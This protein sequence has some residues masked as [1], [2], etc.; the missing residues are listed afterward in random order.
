MK[1][2]EGVGDLTFYDYN[3]ISRNYVFI[4]DNQPPYSIASLSAPCSHYLQ[5][6][7]Q[8]CSLTNIIV[9]LYHRVYLDPIRAR[10]NFLA[11]LKNKDM[12]FMDT[13]PAIIKIFLASSRS[14]KEYI[15]LE[16]MPIDTKECILT[17]AMP[18]FVWVCEI[19]LLDDF[20]NQLLT[21]VLLQDA[22]EVADFSD[23]TNLSEIPV[24]F[25]V[26]KTKVFTYSS[27][28]FKFFTTFAKSFNIYKANLH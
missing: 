22:T 17:T 26:Y 24:F 28:R 5:K 25:G 23:Q 12:E 13:D 18:K 11:V 8:N 9:P 16:D 1:L 6:E 20:K 21:G 3:K 10:K 7:W 2:E 19:S 15:A 14:Y 4:D 27:H